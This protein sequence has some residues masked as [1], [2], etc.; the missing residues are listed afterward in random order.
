VVGV[1]TVCRLVCSVGLHSCGRGLQLLQQPV[2]NQVE[3][4]AG[5]CADTTLLLRFCAA[6]MVLLLT[7]PKVMQP[8]SR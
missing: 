3:L 5:F 2:K 1:V 7:N 6:V 8:F 4:A